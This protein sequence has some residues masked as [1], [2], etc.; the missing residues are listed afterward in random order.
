MDLIKSFSR[1]ETR[2]GKDARDRKSS[3]VFDQY[4]DAAPSDQNAIDLLPGW[5]CAFPPQMGLVAGPLGLFDDQRIA[6]ALDTFGTI[7]DK[8]V[9]E[10]GPLEAMHTFMLNARKPARIDAVE[11]NRLSFMRCLI[12]AQ[13]L[14]IDRAR[15]WLG[16]I[17][18][19]LQDHEDRYDL[20]MASGVLYHMMN[21]P[22]FLR[23][24]AQRTDAI[25]LWTHFF[26]DAAMPPEDPRRIPFSGKQ[27]I[28]TVAGVDARC[29]ERS[30]KNAAK[31]SVFCGGLAD[32]HYWMHRDDIVAL[33]RA[34][35]FDRIDISGE[36]LT[37]PGGPCFCVLARRTDPAAGID[38]AVQS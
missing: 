22:E 10:V 11:A 23:L 37:H 21:P 19:W 3:A 35:G 32:R 15:F 20:I 16:D 24:L 2:G 25:F 1:K 34:L 7:E 13:I 28:Q 4:E 14:G 8:A 38:H 29:Y 33:L 5:N 26:L 36:D 9:L 18:K 31:N 30:Y 12:T 17:S 6:W 27:E